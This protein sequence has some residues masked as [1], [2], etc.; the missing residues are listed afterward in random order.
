MPLSFSSRLCSLASV[1]T[2]TILFAGLPSQVH[3]A[4]DLNSLVPALGNASERQMLAIEPPL[5]DGAPCGGGG[6]TLEPQ[7]VGL[8][9]VYLNFEGV[10]LTSSESQP[11]DATTNRTWMINSVVAPGNT[12][13]I[14]AFNRFDLGDQSGATSRQ[15]IID[16]TLQEMRAY[17]T[18]YNFAFTTSRPS[19]GTYHMVVFGGT[20]NG[21]VGQDCAGIAP[22]DCSDSS[23]SNIVFAF[24]SGLR[25]IDLPTTAT[26][27]L[28]HA[29]GLSHTEDSSDFMY[30]FIQNAL[31]TRYGEG[32]IPAKD[33]GPC[34]NG[35]YQD[36]HEKLLS[37]VGFPGQDGAPPMVSITSP[38]NLAI[39]SFGDAVE[40]TIDDASPIAKVE[41]SIDNVVY[42]TKTSPPYSFQIPDTSP[43]GQ[44]RLEV[45]ATDD[46]GNAAGNKVTVYVGTGNEDPCDSGECPSGY[47]CIDMLC[48]PS[49]GSSGELGGLCNG[50]ETCDSGVCAAFEEEERCSQTCDAENTCPEGFDCLSDTACWPKDEATKS[51]GLCSIAKPGR[52]FVGALGLLFLAL[53]F[54]RRRRS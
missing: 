22:L 49:S 36:S 15:Q 53:A 23:P 13:S 16:Y 9:T 31:P 52:G 28:A 7:A 24:P 2:A 35:S 1:A 41:L 44:V 38:A 25:A 50:N 29:L 10:T 6:D 33:Q 12:L 5:C 18:P 45:R 4:P 17:H 51:S 47:D 48:F 42:E 54:G 3:A 46:Q 19:S 11:D 40:A 39:V 32:P 14:P 21:V 20:C 43:L 8:R 34:G 26:Q 27:E 30:P 37:I